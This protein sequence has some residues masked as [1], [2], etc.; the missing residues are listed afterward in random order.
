MDRNT[1]KELI[2]GTFNFPFEENRFRNF[3]INLLN[4]LDE[5]KSFGYISGNYIKDKFKPHITKYRRLGTYTDPNEAKI[6]VLF[7]QI[8]NE[9]ALERSRSTLRN[10]VADYLSNRDSKDA[11]LVAYY[12]SDPDDWRFSYI[13]MEYRLGTNESGK[14]TVRKDITPAKRFSFLVGKNEPNHTAQAQLL[15]ILANDHHNPTLGSL[16]AAFSV[17][18]ISKQFYLDYRS[19]FESLHTELNNIL[20]SDMKIAK[21]FESKSIDPANF[22]KK[23]LGQIVFLYFLQKKGWLGVGRD[24][25]GNFKKWGMGPKNFL[26]Q[27]FS[28]EFINY[29]NFFNEV[30]EPLFY[31]ALASEHTNDY[32]SPL[33]CKIPFLNGGL[34]EPLKDYNWQETDIRIEN[35]LMEKVF[36]TFDQY[37]FTVREDEP[38][39]KEVAID[40]EM[41]GKVFENLLPENLRKGKGTYYTPRSIVHYMCRESLINYLD[42]EVASVPKQ[43]IED[44]ISEDDVILELETQIDD[45]SFQTPIHDSIR[46]HAQEIDTALANIKVCDPAIGSGAFPVGLLH[47]IVKARKVLE[48]FIGKEVSIYSLKRHCIQ[49]SIYGVDIDPGAIDIAKLRLWLSLVVDEDD[50]SGIQALPNLDYKIMQGNSLIEE[51]HGISLDINKRSEQLDAFSGSSSLSDLDELVEELHNKQADFFNAEHPHD[52]KN[53]RQYVET[54]IFNIFH[55]ELEK[56]KSL[57]P[58]ESKNIEAELKEMTHGNKERNFFPWR[59]YFAD[60]FREKGGFDVV[61]GNPPYISYYSKQAKP[62]S[63][64]EERIYKKHY[65]FI[66]NKLK[67]GRFGTVMFFLEKGIGLLKNQGTNNYIIDYNIFE[68]PYYDI[69]KYI[70][71]NFN[72]LELCV[73]LAAFENVHSGQIIIRIGNSI[74]SGNVIAYKS[75]EFEL[76]NSISQKSLATDYNWLAINEPVLLKK[77]ENN[78]HTLRDHFPQRLIRTGITFTG[79][80]SNFLVKTSH[81]TK[82]AKKGV[83]ILNLYEGSKA[84]PSPYSSPVA[85]EK[86]YYDLELCKILNEEY[87]R[88][89]KPSKNPMVIGLADLK[90]FQSPRILI[91]L[92][93]TRIT[94]TYTD[95]VACSDL[96]LYSISNRNSYN[97]KS[98]VDLKLILG[99]LNST[100]I[101]YYCREKRIIIME[102]NK[103]PQIRLKG[104]KSIP[105]RIPN[106]KVS[107]NI[108]NMVNQIID[109]KKT[110]SIKST[111]ELETQIDQLVY[112]LYELTK[113][114]I[115]IVEASIN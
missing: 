95:E 51:F 25:E 57:S 49:E 31:E 75:S 110:I 36:A 86:I 22:A 3:A 50:Y 30:L 90:V 46:E 45:N 64:Y 15:P 89:N 80:K 81:K 94:A 100:L 62:L 99:I 104:L 6:D 8:K 18:A 27:L 103:T 112:E 98:D 111:I 109:E 37:N 4:N 34:F 9:W 41:L 14:V 7:V 68:N 42:T 70:T 83:K 38:L 115:A 76:T 1:A 47:E 13:R 79:K 40:P 85:T 113:E 97:H 106:A 16:E 2:K 88:S 84:I 71:D 63:E 19:L 29:G 12:S 39:E 35:D 60:V 11:A 102:K 73:G 28:K 32:Y 78:S 5:E 108:I 53:K 65:S 87:R 54:A 10:F 20:D 77:I 23:L 114:E 59:L 48:R 72:I 43:H 82:K 21:E 61:I 58:Q 26:H 66:S 93:D 24:D 101:T 74:N 67:K 96:S 52:K 33:D 69:R 105:I 55:H 17:D 107:L 56:K 91:R 92:S 44:L